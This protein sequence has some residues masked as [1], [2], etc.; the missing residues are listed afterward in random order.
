MD[1]PPSSGEHFSNRALLQQ[2]SDA[3][4]I[5]NK[6]RR[7]RYAN[8]AW[9]KLTG[10]KI[11]D[12]YGL[13]CTHRRTDSS[14]SALG[15][16]LNPPPEALAGASAR[17]RRP[18]P[19]ARLGPPWWEISFLPI[20]A[21]NGLLA[22][23][24]VVRV[25]GPAAAPKLRAIPEAVQRLR[26]RLPDRFRFDDMESDIP[27]CRHV[28]AQARLAAGHFAPVALIGDGGVGKRT[29]ARVIHHGGVT[30]ERSFLSIDCPGLPP[31]VQE[32]LLF[33]ECGLAQADRVGTM[34]LRDPARLSR[35]LQ[36]RLVEWLAQKSDAG[37]RFVS[38]F[39]THPAI[40]VAMGHLLEELALALTIQT[41]LPIPLRDRIDDIPR[42]S[43]G[44]LARA[45]ESGLP[46]CPGL[47]AEA[48]ETARAYMWPGNLRE[49]N[50]ALIQALSLAEGHPIQPG[51]WPDAIRRHVSRTEAAAAAPTVRPVQRPS[52]DAVL[53]QV[54]R[55]LIVQAMAR[56]NGLH[57]RAAELL[58]IW[59]TRL[60][61]R[62]KALKIDEI[63]WQRLA[64]L[65]TDNDA[66]PPNRG[67][68][69]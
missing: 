1:S 3:V 31:T 59:R 4:F 18:C 61:R 53:E 30:A 28:I 36:G 48:L 2:S 10:K 22:I 63:E 39:E 58:G 68:R 6:H 40:D 46:K 52:L 69:D 23:I 50:A 38:I 26:H 14:L 42:L 33:G 56:T 66:L 67:V 47:S 57:E 9:E 21:A 32:T 37:P 34:V 43:A 17:V 62:L 60:G 15:R 24:G 51:H 54:E 13:R 44:M 8:L 64:A 49:L 19:G 65:E 12:V 41:I 27:A 20:S 25:V 35:D 5:L 16:T 7:L 55:R 45:E 29:L 11:G